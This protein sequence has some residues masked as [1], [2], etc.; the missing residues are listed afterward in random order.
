MSIFLKDDKL[1]HIHNMGLGNIAQYISIDPNENIKH[2]M[3]NEFSNKTCDLKELVIE[4]IKSSRTG[5]VNI[6]SFSPSIMKGNTLIYNKNICDIDEIITEV[7]KNCSEGKHSIINENIDVNDGGVSGVVLGDV[8]EFAPK[9]TP[10]CVD[11]EGVCLLEKKLGYHILKTV[12]GFKPEFC[13][14]D[15]YRVEFSIHPNREGVNHRHTIVWEYELFENVDHNVKIMWPNKFSKFIGDKTFGL[16]I[17]DYLGFNVPFTIAITR[18]VAPFTFGKKTGLFEKWIRTCP[19]TKEP[20]RYYTSSQ[21]TDP[22]ILMNIEEE[23]GDNDINIAA[24]LSQDA[25]ESKYSG[26]AIISKYEQNDVVE[27]VSGNGEKFMLGEEFKS[28]LPKYVKDELKQVMNA[29]RGYNDLLGD[30]SIEW[31]YDDNKIWVVQLNQL[32]NNAYGNIIVSGKP[33]TYEKFIVEDGLEALRSKIQSIK[34]KN[35]GIELV[36][37]IGITS[38]FGDLLRQS[39]IPSRVVTI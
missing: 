24:I 14:G 18:E 7:K 1:A 17:A 36:G 11:K 5:A 9:D 3:I 19:I 34:N 8:V 37:N 21:W 22:F 30:V 35:I 4:L 23:K 29:F 27:G 31:V 15:E 13:F 28:F 2:V 6:R 16:M 10:K 25:V 26:G 38:H 39:N 20:G 33:S 12:Y 32:K